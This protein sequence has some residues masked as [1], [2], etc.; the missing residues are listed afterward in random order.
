MMR[1]IG[2]RSV[3]AALGPYALIAAATLLLML[4]VIAIPGYYSHD[5]WQKADHIAR[6]G[7]ADY[8]HTYV[9]IYAGDEFGVPVRPLSF[10]VLGLMAWWMPDHPFVVHLIDVLIHLG[11]VLLLY[12]CVVRLTAKRGMALA[13]ALIFAASPLAIPSVVWAAALMDRL[14]VFWGLAAFLFTEPF[15][16]RRAGARALVPGVLCVAFAMLSKETAMV[17]PALLA[18]WAIATP[19]LRRERRLWIA[20]AAWSL[21][22]IAFLLL[23]L[24]ALAGTL[25]KSAASSYSVSPS[26]VPGSLLLYFAY[27]FVVPL[28]EAVNW[29]FVGKPLVV[30]AVALHAA[31]VAAIGRL[32]GWRYALAYVAMYVLCLAPVLIIPIHASHYLYGSGV[33]MA[34]GLAALL[35]PPGGVRTWAG[36]LAVA[37]IMAGLAHCAV[38]E[39]F[40][41]RLGACMSRA[42][43]SAEAAYLS[44]GQPPALR[45]TAEPGAP[46][47]VLHRL[48][49]GRDQL[50]R[51]GPP[52]RFIIQPS[53]DAVPEGTVDLAFGPDCIVWRPGTG[54]RAK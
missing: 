47:H 52:V 53:S 8:M 25:A 49:T 23:R 44:A 3:R 27:P 13:S 19:S 51:P 26:N 6:F 18:A 31:V 33:A 37:A 5:E 16:A 7:L 2:V 22:V 21:P 46:A 48:F 42:A 14:Y 43:D 32:W 12:A 24:P 40:A 54:E 39:A 29:V 11:V 17:L 45:F 50:L 9:R 20:A 4:P 1:G 30:F 34:V 15:I 35:W 41:Y 28:A 36:G 38:Y 10:A